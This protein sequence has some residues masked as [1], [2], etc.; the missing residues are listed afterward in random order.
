MA[1]RYK[2]TKG[3]TEA[4]TV[5]PFQNKPRV[6]EPPVNGRKKFCDEYKGMASKRESFLTAAKR[7]AKMSL[8]QL[9]NDTDGVPTTPQAS[10]YNQ[11][12]WQ[13]LA[14]GGVNHL[15]NK[16]VLTWFPPVRPFFK[17]SFTDTA[18]K[19]LMAA[20]VDDAALGSLLA[21][22]E[23]KAMDWHNQHAGRIAW[24]QASKH[25]QVSGNAML[26]VPEDENVVCYPLDRYVIKR[27]KGGRVLK[28][29][30]E[31]FKSLM[32]LP[33][34]VQAAVKAKRRNVKPDQDIAV[35]TKIE[36][37]A[38]KYTIR[39]EV[40]GMLVGDEKK[41]LEADLPFIPMVWDR[42][43]GED[44]GRGLIE[45][46]AGDIYCYGFLAE[47][48]A[49]GAALMSQVKFLIRRGSA[50]SPTQ[51][52]AAKS[53]DY[54]WGE[55]GDV[56]VVQLDKYAD[57]KS[58]NEVMSI[59]ER[60]IGN[61]FLMQ[62]AVRRQAERVTAEEIRA[63]A[64]ELETALGGTYT[65]IATSGQAPY[66]RL[67]LKRS[68]F[69]LAAKDVVPTIV[70]GLDALGKT[71]DLDKVAQFSQMMQIPNGWAPEARE[72]I[73]WGDYMSFCLSNLNMEATF[74][75]TKEQHDAFVKAQQAQ[76][77][78]QAAMEAM[79]KIA[80]QMMKGAE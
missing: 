59:Y 35:Y 61:A 68:G 60:R 52:A 76:Q 12:G 65:H 31:E 41:V 79:G 4:A 50:T 71:S 1:G 3:G 23:N 67:L 16:L 40:E 25:L 72:W 21:S 70:T 6:T 32:E 63:D 74:L 56:N 38:G 55:E 48:I 49:K 77:Q 2:V 57:L 64:Q 27:S 22:G 7:Y 39:E 20:R 10:G 44:Y 51:H 37:K 5:N 33:Q 11:N 19:A 8:P 24:T 47:A 42:L 66:A 73:N 30:L 29:I 62:S 15:G 18:K 34:P 54:L 58:V 46:H 80:P 45:V 28:I 36:W 17:M 69:N 9:F 43:Y 75:M 13:S 53:G 78:Q 14:A 26:Y